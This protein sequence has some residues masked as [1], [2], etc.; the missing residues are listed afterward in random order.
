MLV[1]AVVGVQVGA[2][3]NK[4][5]V[6]HSSIG[7]FVADALDGVQFCGVTVEALAGVGSVELV[8]LALEEPADFAGSVSHYQYQRKLEL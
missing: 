8:A 3:L 7:V 4:Q 5:V 6:L 1:L 2:L